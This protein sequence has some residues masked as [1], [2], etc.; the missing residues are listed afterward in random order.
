M[1]LYHGT[2]VENLN[3]ILKKGLLPRRVTKKS[4][5]KGIGDLQSLR[6]LVYFT[7]TPGLAEE[8]AQTVNFDQ[9]GVI[10]KVN[11]LEKCLY[12]DEDFINGMLDPDY[13]LED[14]STKAVTSFKQLAEYKHLWKK[15]LS[16]HGTAACEGVAPS[17]IVGYLKF[18]Y[19]VQRRWIKV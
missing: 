12:P 10:I 5:Y 1:I 9:A 2:C 8:L 3:S 11:V 15:S 19:D 16:K 4:N 17:R 6:E 7:K 14:N 13:C 18:G